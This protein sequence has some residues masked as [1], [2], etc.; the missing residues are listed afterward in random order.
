MPDLNPTSAPVVRF[1]GIVKAVKLRLTLSRFEGET[2]AHAGG[3]VIA[4][5]GTRA[6]PS[7]P[8]PVPG[9]LTVALGPATQEKRQLAPGDL[10][11][12]D[13]RPV[14]AATPD[15]PADLYRVGTLRTIARA[16]EPGGGTRPALDP[17]RTDPAPT[18]AQTESAPRRALDPAHLAPGGPCAPCPYGLVVAIVRLADPRDFRRGQW[19]H[20]SACLGPPDCPHYAPP[21]SAAG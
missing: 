1:Y 14:P 19:S 12:G 11:R 4:L 21:P 15:V 8:A 2:T 3:Y 17:P 6:A 18:V 20:V 13:A 16:G 10:V 7:D 9:H 5:D